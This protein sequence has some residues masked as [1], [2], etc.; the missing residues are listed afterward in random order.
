[1]NESIDV[2]KINVGKLVYNNVK[3]LLSAYIPQPTWY[4]K[5]FISKDKRE[6]AELVAVYGMLHIIKT[7]YSH[8]LID[9]VTSYINLELQT[10]L[11]G[12]INVRDLENVFKLPTKN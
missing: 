1:M 6:L 5:L 8:Y 2:A 10:K 11:I 3:I 9:V 12:S 4:Q 7:K